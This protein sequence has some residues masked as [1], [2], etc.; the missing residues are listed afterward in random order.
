M[1]LN[2]VILIGVGATV[3]DGGAFSLS[4]SGLAVVGS[5]SVMG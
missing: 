1:G 3:V 4:A 5:E 2:T